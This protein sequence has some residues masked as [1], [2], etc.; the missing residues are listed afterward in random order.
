ML[1]PSQAIAI[2]CALQALH[3]A[4]LSTSETGVISKEDLFAAPT[5][6]IPS[7]SKP[8]GFVI[9]GSDDFHVVV[10]ADTPLPARRLVALPV[11]AGVK[12]VGVEVWEGE[13]S[14]KVDLIAPPPRDEDDSE[15][16]DDEPEEPEEVASVVKSAKTFL[17]AVKVGVKAAKEAKVLVEVIVNDGGVEV[18]AWEEGAEGEKVG[19]KA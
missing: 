7:T 8:I 10:P 1:D 4:Q 13:E 15:D 6:D 9:P 12:E 17:V 14:I 2:G 16:E 19:V 5:T 18:N 11:S 3:L